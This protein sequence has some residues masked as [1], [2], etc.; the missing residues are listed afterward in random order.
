MYPISKLAYFEFFQHQTFPR[1]G[2]LSTCLFHWLHS[3]SRLCG[4]KAIHF[5]L[6]AVVTAKRKVKN[7]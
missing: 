1:F 5:I 4:D 6:E 3:L 2:L 7:L